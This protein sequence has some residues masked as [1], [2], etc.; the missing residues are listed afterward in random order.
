MPPTN[1]QIIL[2]D[3]QMNDV[4]LWCF[5]VERENASLPTCCTNSRCSCGTDIPSHRRFHGKICTHLHHHLPFTLKNVI[6]NTIKCLLQCSAIQKQYEQPAS[7]QQ[8]SHLV[9]KPLSKPKHQ[10]IATAQQHSFAK[11]RTLQWHNLLKTKSEFYNSSHHTWAWFSE[12]KSDFVY[13]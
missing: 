12:F 4:F 13:L 6:S 7:H 5:W 2:L 8:G 3:Q 10:G 9:C 11:R 1:P